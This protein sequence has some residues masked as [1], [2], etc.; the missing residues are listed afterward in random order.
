MTSNPQSMKLLQ[1]ALANWRQWHT[2]SGALTSQPAMVREL[3]GGL[4]NRSFLVASDKFK[5]VVRI[6]ATNSA[7]LGIDRQ[8]ERVIL[9]LLQPIG[10]VPKVLFQTDDVLVSAFCEG[11][12]WSSADS[13]SSD[14]VAAVNQ[15]L[16]R[17]QGVEAPQLLRRNYV[18]YCQHYID[19]LEGRAVNEVLTQSILEAAAAIDG[20]QWSAVI[21]HHDLVAENILLTP[22][23]LIFID[24][25]YAALGHPLLD[26]V[27]LY[28][29]DLP[30]GCVTSAVDDDILK[31]LAILQHGMDDLWSLIQT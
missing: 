23:G 15:M 28:G 19:Q 20:A 21:C 7:S 12:L 1:Q 18:A 8:R 4:T 6:N 11:Q 10:A 27:R 25:E 16:Q 31:Q 29:T 17:I 9:E 24:W 2:D 13:R 5:A 26:L 3:S 14:K 22:Q 30:V